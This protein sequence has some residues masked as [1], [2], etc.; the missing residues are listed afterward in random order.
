[1]GFKIA[2]AFVEVKSNAT[3]LRGEVSREVE[4]AGVGQDIKVGLQLKKDALGGLMANLAPLIL[5]VVGAIGQLTG[6]LGLVP[7][8]A[9]AAGTAYGA[10]K[11]GVSGFSD[12][13][14]NADAAKNTTELND[15]LK[16][17]AP[18]ARESALA[19]HNL[20]PAWNNLH[21]DVQQ[22][23]FQG[24]SKDIQRLGIVDLPVL[25]TGL[26][27]TAGALN[28]GVHY[29]TAWATSSKTVGDLRTIMDNSA[30]STQNLMR[31]LQPVL[32][33]VR[34]IA[35]VGSTMLPGLSGGFATAAQHAA[36]FISHARETGK[37][38]EWIQTGIDATGQLFHV[39]GDLV[40]IIIKIGQSPPLFG[41]SF[42][43]ALS[44]VTD[45]ILKLV[46]TFPELLPLIE[47]GLVLWRAWAI[48]QWAVNAAMA[49]NPI[50]LVITAIGALVTATVLIINHWQAVK[51]FLSGLWNWMRD[52]ASAVFSG[53]QN[54]VSSRNQALKDDFTDKWNTIRNVATSVWNGISNFITGGLNNFRGFWS[55]VWNG[56]VGDFNNIWG[57][58]TGIANG[59]WGA[60]TGAF[61]AGVNSVVNLING[62]IDDVDKVLGFL[63]LALIP[64]VPLFAA[65]GVV[66]L[67][68][69]GTVGAGFTTRGPMAIVGEG[70]PNHPEYVIPTDPAH[71]KNA[72]AL[73]QA[74]GAQL[75]AEGGILSTVTDWLGGGA[76]AAMNAVIDRLA[77]IIPAGLFRDIASGAG[78]MAAAGIKTMLDKVFASSAGGGD[79]GAW[80]A[81]ALAITGTPP[82]WGGPL[83]TLI[84]RESGG[85]P[86]AINLWDSN[87]RAG[88]PSQGLMQ[89]IPGTFMAYHQPGTSWSITDP[90]AN[91]AAG[92]NYI[93]ARYGSIFN[94]QQANPNLPP[95]GYDL[96]GIATGAG[97]LPKYTSAPE[98][99]LS[100]QQTAD[101]GRL[102]DLLSGK[103]RATLGGVTVN[104]T[105]VMGSP[106]ETGRAVALALRTVG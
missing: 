99:V 91:I 81:T 76:S 83:R 19:V 102:V 40:Q 30:V 100:P 73:Y 92:I 89:T 31:A 60:V 23:L 97:F 68:G 11:V 7:A 42:L 62:L 4:A 6:A 10:L 26:D 74:L 82:S 93:K 8:S 1:M 47:A 54:F 59:I 85:N 9:A 34:D 21:L 49:A 48:A 57:R 16:E 46:T 71:R 51:D 18:N 35:T 69:G 56:I 70:D 27:Q 96:G 64:R 87:A 45:L 72:L 43:S 14:K 38:R 24:V 25:R 79:L 80:I 95:K 84:M 3:G 65:G 15:A 66:G 12:A 105:Q 44:A 32:G 36:D 104:V 103:G 90:V 39:L 106:A 28:Q 55:G 5:P 77:A 53:I 86:N 98:R 94:V 75:M 63:H 88:H 78:H 50:G 52:T 41:V 58:I 17:L 61:R 37:L 2:E 67:A 33:M 29:F 20:E 101:F 22:R 13:L